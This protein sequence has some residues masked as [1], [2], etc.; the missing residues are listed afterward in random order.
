MP[1]PDKPMSSP[2]NSRNDCSR[3]GVATAGHRVET[4]TRIARKGRKN[5]F[6]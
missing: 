6:C 1:S 4:T 3:A 2:R 5:A